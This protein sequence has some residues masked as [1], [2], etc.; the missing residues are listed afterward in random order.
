MSVS[1]DIKRL[2]LL[3]WVAVF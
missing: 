3:A 2:Y 1:F